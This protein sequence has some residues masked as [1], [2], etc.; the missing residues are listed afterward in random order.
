MI[1]VI[2][3]LGV[4]ILSIVKAFQFRGY[5]AIGGEYLIIPLILLALKL[6]KYL[7]TMYKEM[8]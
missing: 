3:L 2:M 4:Q 6:P 7:V 5:L 8:I 1:K